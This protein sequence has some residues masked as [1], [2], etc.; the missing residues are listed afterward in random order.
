[1]NPCSSYNGFG[2]TSGVSNNYDWNQVNNKGAKTSLTDKEKS[3]ISRDKCRQKQKEQKEDQKV[4]IQNLTSEN[5]ELRRKKDEHHQKLSM[6]KDIFAA[7]EKVQGAN[8]NPLFQKGKT[9]LSKFSS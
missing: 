8:N 7:H 9:L 4:K 2:G 1:M 5:Q 6:L 3:K